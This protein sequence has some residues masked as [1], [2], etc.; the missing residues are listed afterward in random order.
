MRKILIA[1]D[2][3]QYSEAALA[4]ASRLNEKDPVTVIGV[5]LPLTDITSY[6]SYA[7]AN[8]PDEGTI[9]LVE[10][11]VAVVIRNNM[12]RFENYCIDRGIDYRVHTDYFDLAIPELKKESRFADLLIINSE[13]FYANTAAWSEEYLEE[14]LRA[15]E[16]PVL[17]VPN[18]FEFPTLNILSYDGSLSSVYAIK[19]FA[20]L[21]PELANNETTLVHADARG[22]KPFPDELNIEN[23]VSRHFGNHH[24]FKFE[25]DPQRYFS[26]WL[27]NTR[28]AILVSGAFG[29]SSLYRLFHESFISDILRQHKVPLFIAHK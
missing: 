3:S 6:W 17:V 24:L 26:T 10:K 8:G 22:D 5:F 2:G 1:F 29:G 18:H 19:Q 21:L 28:S 11:S 7:D 15:M 9:P 25:A 4:F 13:S 23:L 16:C 12:K 14:T 20:Y 27:S